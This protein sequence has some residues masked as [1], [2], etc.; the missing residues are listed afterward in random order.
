MNVLKIWQKRGSAEGLLAPLIIKEREQ[1]F[2]LFKPQS[3]Q[4]KYERPRTPV[5]I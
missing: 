1:K 4:L 3:Q 2:K 5:I